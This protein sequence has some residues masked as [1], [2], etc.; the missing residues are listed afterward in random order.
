MSKF[1]FVSPMWI[2]DSALAGVRLD[3][4]DYF[5]NPTAPMGVSKPP[6]SS[7]ATVALPNIMQ[8]RPKDVNAVTPSL[9]GLRRISDMIPENPVNTL[10][11]PKPMMINQRTAAN[12]GADN[13]P[14]APPTAAPV[15]SLKQA[16][17]N[18]KLSKPMPHWYSS[19]NH[20]APQQGKPAFRTTQVVRSTDSMNE[21]EGGGGGPGQMLTS[22]ENPN[23]VSDYFASS[24]LHHLSRWRIDFQQQLT[25]FLINLRTEEDNS[26]QQGKPISTT[27]AHLAEPTNSPDRIIAHVDMD[28][29]FVSV[30][31]RN[32]PD[33]VGR[34]VVVS[35]GGARGT[36]ASVNYE[37]RRRGLRNGWRLSEAERLCGPELAVLPYNFEAYE[38]VSKAM[39]EVF[40]K[41]SKQIQVLSCD[42]ALLDL[43]DAADK[44][45]DSALSI[46]A[47]IRTEVFEKTQCDCSAGLGN[48][49]T[50]ASL[51]LRKAKPNGCVAAP[52][53]VDSLSADYQL[54]QKM[55]AVGLQ[56]NALAS[57]LERHLGGLS[58]QSVSRSR[59]LSWVSQ[60]SLGD[61]KGVGPA[62]QDKLE[63]MNIKTLGELQLCSL[64]RSL[65]LRPHQSN[66]FCA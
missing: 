3:A 53:L 40:L 57:D 17:T 24:R 26:P 65:R 60:F 28:A 36:C 14:P 48:S 21:S 33:L 50:L 64:V 6:P 54:M 23:F 44:S 46:L 39:Y 58:K 35:H 15:L 59:L 20:A 63:E 19:S 32:R 2:V 37:A 4:G 51:A 5:P 52:K 12:E 18:E 61:L 8:V 13:A 38:E 25:S 9:S 29:F 49:R 43:T 41:Y 16:P 27:S 62:I 55:A 56:P 31:C 34:P 11:P 47:R 30:S 7:A 10:S 42:E 66:S 45:Y 1:K 22:K